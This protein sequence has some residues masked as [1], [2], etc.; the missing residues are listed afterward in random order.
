MPADDDGNRVCGVKVAV[1]E[2]LGASSLFGVDYFEIHI[3]AYAC[4][5]KLS[6]KR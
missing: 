6:I 4:A 3:Y 2:V 5:K 1:V